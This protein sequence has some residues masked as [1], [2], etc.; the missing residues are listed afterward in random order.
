MLGAR[1]DGWV[2]VSVGF[3][4]RSLATQAVFK[5]GQDERDDTFADI[6]AGLEATG[7]GELGDWMA[8]FSSR[9]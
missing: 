2:C 6:L 3:R 4:A 8:R 1:D 9:G 7:M 5:L